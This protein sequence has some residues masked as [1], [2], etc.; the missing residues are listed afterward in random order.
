[1]VGGSLSPLFGFE[2]GAGGS[3]WGWQTSGDANLS[4]K[5]M[6]EGMQSWRITSYRFLNL[7]SIL[8]QSLNKVSAFWAPNCYLLFNFAWVKFFST[9]IQKHFSWQF[10][11]Q[12][13]YTSLSDPLES[14][15]LSILLFW[16]SCWGRPEVP[17]AHQVL[18]GCPGQDYFLVFP[19]H[20]FSCN[21]FSHGWGHSCNRSFHSLSLFSFRMMTLFPGQLQPQPG[22]SK[23]VVLTIST[24]IEGRLSFTCG[25]N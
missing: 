19:C 4:A 13:E 12:P 16:P 6:F 17:C 20:L 18:W 23:L 15:L 25:E 1:M 5:L 22:S 7:A 9:C 8:S 11:G 3:N 14:L 21:L 10:K 24:L 2:W